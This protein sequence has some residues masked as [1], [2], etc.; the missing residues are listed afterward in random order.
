MNSSAKAS[1]A[2][3]EVSARF[4]SIYRTLQCFCRCIILIAIAFNG[5]R[6]D[7]SAGCAGR[8]DAGFDPGEPWNDGCCSSAAYVLVQPNGKILLGGNTDS[9]GYRL[10]RLNPDGGVDQSFPLRSEEGV[11]LSGGTF[12]FGGSHGTQVGLNVTILN[13]SLA[14]GNETFT[15]RLLANSIPE[16][17]SS[18]ATSS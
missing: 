2:A 1:R 4:P 3:G 17:P 12:P 18:T 14:E 6:L 13:D 5:P 11:L 15:V 9:E 7:A 16:S 8:L 10:I